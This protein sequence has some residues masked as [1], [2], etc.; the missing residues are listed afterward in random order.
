MLVKMAP[1]I[2]QTG[3]VESSRLDLMR[4]DDRAAGCGQRQART[5]SASRF[6]APGERPQT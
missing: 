2:K 6:L 3:A 1:I 5:M 4:Y